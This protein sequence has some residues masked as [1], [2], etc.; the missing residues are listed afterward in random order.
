M[1]LK[2]N[3]PLDFRMQKAAYLKNYVATNWYYNSLYL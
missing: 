3:G 2:F 1:G